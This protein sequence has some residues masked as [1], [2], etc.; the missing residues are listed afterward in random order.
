MVN[1]HR[2]M[3]VSFCDSTDE[4][5]GTSLLSELRQHRKTET[6]GAHVHEESKNI[7]SVETVNAI[8][9]PWSWGLAAGEE[10]GK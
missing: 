7:E 2:G 8:M 5:G 3:Q 6:T 1:V 9:A 10:L 4:P